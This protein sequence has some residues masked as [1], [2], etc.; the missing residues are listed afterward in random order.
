M[1][2]GL[3][4]FQKGHKCFSD[5]GQFLKG[6]IPWNKGK[7]FSQFSGYKHP[8]WKGG[9]SITPCGYTLIY[10]PHHPQRDE[11]NYVFEHRLVMEKYL[12]R[13]LKSEE[14]VHHVNGIKTDN[15]IKNLRLFINDN[16]HQKHHWRS[17]N[18]ARNN[19]T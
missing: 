14:V 10:C 13:Y 15:R 17:K 1:P 18:G 11:R 4:G 5:K 12:K 9:K 2:K 8:N 7:K 16:E 19:G 3:E 6:Q